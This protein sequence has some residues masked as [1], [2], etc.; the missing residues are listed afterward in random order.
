MNHRAISVEQHFTDYDWP[1]QRRSSNHVQG[2][3][4]ILTSGMPPPVMQLG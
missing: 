3:L 2:Y 1:K 4:I